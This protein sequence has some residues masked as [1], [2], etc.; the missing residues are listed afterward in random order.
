V[1]T[2]NPQE[3]YQV[4]V[5]A[6]SQDVARL[7]ASSKRLKEMFDMFGTFDALQEITSQRTV[8]LPIRQQAIIQFKNSALSHWKSK[9]CVQLVSSQKLRDLPLKSSH[10]SPFERTTYQHPREIISSAR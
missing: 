4:L 7:Q 2:V 9:K 6:C 5:A 3:L 8:P 1:E 10:Q